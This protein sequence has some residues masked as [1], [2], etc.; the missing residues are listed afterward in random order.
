LASLARVCTAIQ[1]NLEL[2]WEVTWAATAKYT[3]AWS[4]VDNRTSGRL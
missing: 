2:D 3:E 1:P 4:P